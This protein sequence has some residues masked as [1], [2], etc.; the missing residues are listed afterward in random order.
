MRMSEIN[1]SEF[2][3]SVDTLLNPQ[4]SADLEEMRLGTD[5]KNFVNTLYHTDLNNTADHTGSSSQAF[6]T[7]HGYY[8]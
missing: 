1:S 2:S 8:I 4:L 3:E 5:L 6:L 7:D